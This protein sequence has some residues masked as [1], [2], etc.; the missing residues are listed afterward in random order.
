MNI[1]KHNKSKKIQTISKVKKGKQE[2][3]QTCTKQK[4]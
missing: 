2:K 3:H 1:I 4:I